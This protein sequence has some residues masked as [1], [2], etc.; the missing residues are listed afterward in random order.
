[1]AGTKPFFLLRVTS[2]T[3]RRLQFVCRLGQELTIE[4]HPFSGC[5]LYFASGMVLVQETRHEINHAILRGLR[6]ARARIGI[7]R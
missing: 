4:D 3:G 7:E 2:F 1:M 6:A 5:Y